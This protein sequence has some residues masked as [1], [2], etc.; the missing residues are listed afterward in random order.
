MLSEADLVEVSRLIAALSGERRQAALEA[1]ATWAQPLVDEVRR[2]RVRP[3][4]RRAGALHPNAALTEAEVADIKGL[5]AKKIPGKLIASHYGITPPGVSSIGS[6]RTWPHVLP[7][8]SVDTTPFE[9]AAAP[10]RRP[11]AKLDVLLVADVKGLLGKGLSQTAIAAKLGVTK[12][13][14]SDVDRGVTWPEVQ[15]NLAVDPA[16]YGLAAST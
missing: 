13:A 5:L 12:G 6:G 15:P 11:T 1:L 16:A 7:N 3:G 10:L 4:D 14:I 8:M 2:L 9:V